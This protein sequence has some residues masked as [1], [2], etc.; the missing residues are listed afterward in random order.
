M[1]VVD[2]SALAK[3]LLREQGWRRVEEYLEQGV[4]SVDHVVKEVANAIWK[5]AMLT[6]RIGWDT[7]KQLYRLL[8][9]LIGPVIVVEPQDVYL[10]DAFRIAFETGLTVYDAIYVAQARRKGGLLT[11]DAKQAEAARKLGITVYEV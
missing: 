10:D 9:K 6:R 3:Y 4:Y 2:A 11:S 8:K 1:I 5:H 7:A